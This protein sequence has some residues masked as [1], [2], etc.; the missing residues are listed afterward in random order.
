MP[1]PAYRD[2]L[3][4]IGAPEDPVATDTASPWSFISLLKAIY[5]KISDGT[6]AAGI[7]SSADSTIKTAAASAVAQGNALI[8]RARSASNSAIAA[9]GQTEGFLGA[10]AGFAA[11]CAHYMRLA[12]AS[13]S[14]AATSA[15]NAATSETNA[16]SS[17]SSASGYADVANQ[18]LNFVGGMSLLGQRAHKD[19]VAAA[20]SAAAAAASAASI[21]SEGL[22]LGVQ[23]YM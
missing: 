9:A 12:R 15:T 5:S 14:A 19:R 17:A 8:A 23:V 21:T 6:L 16:A 11:T 3:R 2:W 18:A 20:A 10:C 4:A 1:G 22:V 7:A 13:K